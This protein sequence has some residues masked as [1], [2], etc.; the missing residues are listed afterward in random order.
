M[1][2]F[3]FNKFLKAGVTFC[4][5][6]FN[7]H[8]VSGQNNTA[9]KLHITYKSDFQTY[10]SHPIN[11]LDD[12]Y[13]DSTG[14]IWL[15]TCLI[16]NF[17]SSGLISF[18]GYKFEQP[19]AENTVLNR[20]K[21]NYIGLSNDKIY[22]Y[23]NTD[24][25]SYL[26]YYD[27]RKNR[28]KIYDTLSVS[29]SKGSQIDINIKTK[30]PLVIQRLEQDRIYTYVRRRDS[31]QLYIYDHNLKSVSYKPLTL[32]DYISKDGN[33]DFTTNKHWYYIFDYQTED[34][35]KL[36]LKT[37]KETLINYKSENKELSSAVNAKVQYIEF[38]DGFLMLNAPY[39][40]G[41]YKSVYKV[42]D[43][44]K[45]KI[46]YVDKFD[47][48]IG[49]GI[50]ADHLEQYIIYKKI[51]GENYL[52]LTTVNGKVYDLSKII[53]ILNTNEIKRIYSE[54]FLNKL[55]I[56]TNRGF[57][58][59]KLEERNTIKKIK[60]NSPVRG[61]QLIDNN[62]LIYLEENGV[63]D[64]R[65]ID[66]DSGQINLYPAVCEF[67]RLKL[68]RRG[69]LIWGI[70]DGNI[71]SYDT[72]TGI[73]KTY[74]I[75]QDAYLFQFD[76]YGDIIFVDTNGEFWKYDLDSDEVDYLK[77]NIPR[78]DNFPI[79]IDFMIDDNNMLW[80]VNPPLGLF[81]YDFKS[82][83]FE[84]INKKFE[85]FN[86]S[87]ISIAKGNNNELWLGSFGSG[88]IIFNTQDYEYKAFS[89]K[90]GLPNN[91]IASITQDSNGYFWVGTFKGVAVLNAEAKLITNLYETDGLVNNESNRHAANLLPNGR[92]AIGTINGI[93][94]IHPER[95]TSDFEEDANLK[96][97]F[98]SIDYYDSELKRKTIKYGFQDLN[99]IVL[100]PDKKNISLE[101]ANTNYLNPSKNI[102]AYK[103]EGLNKDWI[104]LGTDN[105]LVLSSLP[106]GH[107]LL[108]VKSSNYQGNWSKNVLELNII[109]DT[110][111]YDEI[112]FYILLLVCI[113]SISFFVIW[114]LNRKIK[115]ATQKIR[116]DKKQIENQAEKL[117]VLD[118]AKGEF[119][120]NI[121]HE[122][123]TPLTI[124]KGISQ[125]LKDK[126]AKDSP[127][128]FSD[129]KQ[130]SD[131][132]ID[133]V[134]QILD[135]RKLEANQL[136]LNLFQADLSMFINYIVDSHQ[137]LAQQKQ[138]K[139][140][141]N[142]DEGKIIMDFDPAKLRIVISNLI[143]NAIKYTDHEGLVSVNIRHVKTLNCVNISIKDNGRG[144]SDAELEKAFELFHQS[145]TVFTTKQ[146]GSGIGLYYAKKLVELMHGN[147]HVKSDKGKGTSIE[148]NLAVSN[149][150]S[151]LNIENEN[152]LS[153]SQLPKKEFQGK[154]SHNF[155]VLVVD[156]NTAVRD[157]LK[158]QLEPQYELCFANDGQSALDKTMNFAPDLII[159]DVMMSGMD[160]FELCSTLKTD[161]Q[162][163]HIPVILL[164][165]KANQES[166]IKGLKSGADIYLKKPFDQNE[167]S[168]NI[169][170]LIHSR[171]KLQKKYKGLFSKNG[172]TENSKEDDFILEFKDI[173]LGN[174]DH[175]NFSI[176]QL[177]KELR[178]SRAGLHNKIKA[179]TGLSTSNYIN[180]IKIYKAKELLEE[181]KTYNISEISYKVGITNTNYFSRLFHKEFGMSPSEFQ[182]NLKSLKRMNR[183]K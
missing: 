143:S 93:S 166:V 79:H 60:T 62:S 116:K 29:K 52:Q 168:I 167:L 61:L 161:I 48:H 23:S 25:L 109:V 67:N 7:M 83:T 150:A 45:D 13:L 155:K 24:S 53:E 98:T 19:N 10:P 32:P 180:H 119:F 160:G 162:T 171:K 30:A 66:I 159:S 77:T 156:D 173:V 145:D 120:T 113:L 3:F 176:N 140:E 47:S 151:K 114:F 122:F 130:N 69:D 121:T 92:I 18:D 82:G 80:I 28:Y 95:I 107:H 108:K 49:R 34:I 133:M 1:L 22:G 54:N 131:H 2:N 75:D 125:V 70:R 40:K 137:Y 59:L 118:E 86:Y 43:S 11:C 15:T 33:G 136:K 104:S 124:I 81:K 84:S 127:K 14:K 182:K 128:E 183:H 134:D 101:F 88:L 138:I 73:C 50:F 72:T 96:T 65:S 9:E 71:A 21:K 169:R 175:S 36:N 51:N 16:S 141:V 31:I 57:H 4:L 89:T 41:F 100:P 165:S 91:S 139:L 164:T 157:L 142:S 63:N 102:F 112:W 117:R 46:E 126:Y 78:S 27:T 76:N 5:I 129:L 123:R 146:K 174:L 110:F 20:F 135:L 85:D 179:L 8:S 144:F 115:S 178:L 148:F 44:S 12:F 26:F 177:C 68:L 172:S 55:Y 170:N 106:S 6:L 35:S 99:T 37:G 42:D 97:Y 56:L 154:T 58:V 152:T 181:H 111:F 90:D 163:S 87:L 39:N 132:L 94:L 17:S 149:K 105:K 153:H 103:I 38:Q 147:I 74:E 158:L 64:L